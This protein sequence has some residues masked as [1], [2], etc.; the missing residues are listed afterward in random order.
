MNPIK[1]YIWRGL[2]VL[3]LLWACTSSSAGATGMDGMSAFKEA[4]FANPPQI[5]QFET[6]ASFFGPS[7]H[8]DAK[9]CGEWN[10]NGS[11][12]CGG[13]ITLDDTELKTGHTV[14][15][16]IPVY[17]EYSGNNLYFYGKNNNSWLQEQIMGIPMWIAYVIK[18]RDM[19][20]L[21]ENASAV[22]SVNL[23]KDDGSQQQMQIILNGSRL[24]ELTRSHGTNGS[25][26]DQ[27]FAEYLAQAMEQT[28][29][30]LA[31][32]VDKNTKQTITLTTD[33]T[34]LMRNYAKSMLQASYESKLT[35]TKD[36]Q[37]FYQTIG[38]YCNF[39]FYCNRTESQSKIKAAYDIGRIAKA[40]STNGSTLDILR[41]DAVDATIH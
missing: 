40:S 38:Y 39:K 24:A 36:E 19:T 15:K 33:L 13:E 30:E 25:D 41:K 9:T 22:Q 21:E 34:E 4:Y 18:S 28:S 5:H 27:Q 31:W 2:I 23:I 3:C 26:R 32:V 37:D 11:L 10:G 16:N 8:L 14:K 6:T 12:W 20:V 35:L 1:N 29:L 7:F 17:M